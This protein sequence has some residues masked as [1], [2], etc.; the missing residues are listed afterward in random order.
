VR[1]IG[2]GGAVSV[3]GGLVVAM[4]GFG[5][6]ILSGVLGFFVGKVFAWGTR[7]QSQPPFPV[8]AAVTVVTGMLIAFVL[9]YGTPIPQRGLLPLGLPIAGWFAT[10]GLQQ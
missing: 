1:A 2:A 7:G 3:A 9:V 10:R 4:M 5:S 8:I 6:L